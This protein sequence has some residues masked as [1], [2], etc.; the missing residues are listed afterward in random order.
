MGRPSDE[1]I[2]YLS[3]QITAGLLDNAAHP[4]H[5]AA[6]TAAVRRWLPDTDAVDGHMIKSI[7]L[8]VRENLKIHRAVFLDRLD[9]LVAQGKAE[10]L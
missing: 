5:D 8:A 10:E 1:Q 7:V 9:R 3:S 6:L 2:V 4:D